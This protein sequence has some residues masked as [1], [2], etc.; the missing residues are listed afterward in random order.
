MRPLNPLRWLRIPAAL[1]MACAPCIAVAVEKPNIILIVADDMGYSDAGCF[2]GEIATPALDRLAKEGM[3]LTRFHNA[4]MCVVS[5]ASMMTGK[6]WPRALPDFTKTRLLPEKLHDQGYRCG[7]IGKWHLEG[8]P[9]DRG[10]D[11]FF[12]FLGGFA[13]HFQGGKDYR[14]DREPF[15]GFGPDFYSSDAFTERAIDFIGDSKDRPFF[16]Y[17]SYQAP[18]NPLQAPREMIA[19]Y[20]GR[21]ASGWQAVREARIKRQRLAGL[22]SNDAPVPAYP[23]NLPAWDSLTTAQKDLEDLRMA[24][25]A[26]IIERMDQGIGRLMDHLQRVG[27]ADN[28]LVLFLSDNGT[29]PFSVVDNAMLKQGKLPGDPGSNWQPGMGWAYACNAPWRLYK[30]SQHGGGITTGAIAWWRGNIAK[31]GS[32][33]HEPL[34][35]VD[36]MPT[37]LEAAGERPATGNPAGKSFVPLLRG[38]AWKRDAPLYFQYSDN[39]AIR[40]GEWT[41][42]EVDGSGWEL[43]NAREDPMET[44]NRIDQ[45]HARAAELEAEW[46][47]WWSAQ[48]RKT[49]YHPESSAASVHYKPQGDRG[50]G[51]PYVPSS[52]PARLA[53]R[54]PMP[55]GK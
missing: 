50:S 34:H 53:D 2:G 26:A 9:M 20:R 25:Y 32:I 37:L 35:V 22:V 11:H 3:R 44:I 45:Q 47:A 12:G 5:R 36:V 31:P 8:D 38:N 27:K 42:T 41:L 10:F 19:K 48:S 14:L 4:G 21:Y 23:E 6:W 54:M 15:S 51:R 17:L 13:D 16:L 29:D 24:V 28:T 55:Q 46:S 30:I 33:A 7:L 52:M 18:H 40:S 43:F 1:M 39:R 49:A